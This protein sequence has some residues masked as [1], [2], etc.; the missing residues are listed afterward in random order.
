MVHLVV[1]DHLLGEKCTQDKILAKPMDYLNKLLELC[2]LA[3]TASII[4]FD[5][6]FSITPTQ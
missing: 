5:H 4:A 2:L 3:L 1:M 6:Y